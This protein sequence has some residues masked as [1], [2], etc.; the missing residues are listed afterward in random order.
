MTRQNSSWMEVIRSSE[1]SVHLRTARRYIP[2]G[3]KIHNYLCE[4]FKFYKLKKCLT[5]QPNWRGTTDKKKHE[6]RHMRIRTRRSYQKLKKHSHQASASLQIILFVYILERKAVGHHKHS[7]PRQT[8]NSLSD[9]KFLTFCRARL[10]IIRHT[11][12][13]H[14]N[15]S[16]RR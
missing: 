3:D 4:N 1:T 7:P 2:E 8:G 16:S 11:R 13:R 6:F 5:N 9:E 14:C 10:S 12:T 15:F